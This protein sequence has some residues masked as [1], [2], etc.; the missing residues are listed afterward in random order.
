[1]IILVEEAVRGLYEL[2]YLLL[3]H[4]HKVLEKYQEQWTGKHWSWRGSVVGRSMG[5][6]SKRRPWQLAMLKKKKLHHLAGGVIP[7]LPPKRYDRGIMPWGMQEF[8]LTTSET[9][10]CIL[11]Q[12]S[13]IRS[14]SNYNGKLHVDTLLMHTI[15][16]CVLQAELKSASSSRSR[17]HA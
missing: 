9:T 17:K 15:T 10:Q 3:L 8:V 1:M 4:T 2:S 16:Q 12:A 6:S 13:L 14:T 11:R 5:G 7:M